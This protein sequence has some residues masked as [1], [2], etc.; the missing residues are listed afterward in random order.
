MHT[1]EEIRNIVEETLS[2]LRFKKNPGNL[3]APVQYSLESGGKRIRPV[4]VLMGCN[5]FTDSIEKAIYPAL[6][7]E[8]FHNFTLLHDD[9]MDNS[10]TR[11]G[12]ATIHKKWNTNVAILSG[13][14]MLIKAYEFLS[15]TESEKL[16]LLLKVFNK[17]AL[18]VCEGQQL[19][20]DFE[21]SNRVTEQEYLEMIE[22]KTAVLLAGSLKLGAL[23]GDA[24]EHD[25]DNIYNFGRNLGLAF[26]LQDDYLDLY[27]DPNVF[28]KKIGGDIVAGKKTYLYFKACENADETDRN[29]LNELMYSKSIEREEKINKVKMLYDKYKVSELTD[30]KIKEYYR[31][32][33]INYE[34][35]KVPA[36][37]KE[38]L[39]HLA[40]ILLKREK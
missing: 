1:F 14:A 36:N 30:N 15:K 28:G 29:A 11:R 13:D 32:A 26:Q 2:G 3:Y 18:Q 10:D 7:I 16:P 25:A 38:P 27:G 35:I 6:A 33:E 21:E 24:E 9:I 12:R 20:M 37:R 22:L 4:M 40:E 34:R 23:L 19:D 8:I 17:T 39:W 5:L 31:Q